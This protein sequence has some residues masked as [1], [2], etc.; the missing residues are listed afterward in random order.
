MSTRLIGKNFTPPDLRAKVTGAAKFAEDFRSEGMLHCRLLLSP[1]PNARVL[2]V[3]VSEALKVPGVVAVLTA[4]EVPKMPAPER[5][6]LT[7]TPRFLGDPILAIAA[8]TETAAADGLERIRLEL[9]ALPFVIDPV[10]SLLRHDLNARPEGNVAGRNLPLRTV[11]W[12]KNYLDAPLGEMPDDAVVESW[13]YGDLNAE[14]SKCGLVFEENFVTASFP[15]QSMEPRSAFAYW[16]RGKC[17]IHGSTQSQ[18]FIMPKLAKYVGIDIGNLVFVGEFCGGGFGSKDG[19]YPA[20]AIPA[21]MSKKTGRPVMM[22]ISRREEYFIGSARCGFQGRVKLGFSKDGKLLAV[23]MLVVQDNGANEGF[24]DFIAAGEAVSLVYRPI[25]M[26]Y[27]ALPVLTNTPWRGAQRGPGQNQVAVTLEPLIDKAA[28]QLGID[29]VAIRRINA[30]DGGARF[31]GKAKSVTSAHLREALEKAAARYGWNQKVRMER[32]ARPGKAIGIGVGQAY[33][34][35]GSRGFDGLVCIRPDGRLHIHTGVGNLGTYSYAATSRVAAEV[36]GYDWRRCVIERGDSRRHLPWNLGQFGSNTSFTMTRTNHVAAMDARR[37]I[38][39]IAALDLRGDADDLAIESERVFLRS[40]PS[41]GMSFSQVARRAIEL[42]G[43]YSGQVLPDDLNPMTKASAAALAGQGLIGVSKDNLESG[44]TVAAFAVGM[45]TVE[46]DLE[47]GH[48][49]ILDYVGV[50]DCGTVLHPQG[51]E[52]QISGGLAMGIGMACRERYVYDRVIGMPAN[53]SLYQCKP[54]TYL[55]LPRTMSWDAVE[56]PDPNN[57]VGSKGIGEPV[58][59]C[60]ASALVCAIS[61]ALDGHHFNRTPIS[62]DMIINAVR[63]QP[64]AHFPLQVHTV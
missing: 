32:T 45:M 13:S 39:A 33:H 55:E 59:G 56:I 35:A 48:V 21:H 14:F 30:P 22:R 24:D 51:L 57:P 38:L 3:D 25:A 46:L 52:Q 37:K 63:G 42:G 44:G 36:L 19:A 40:R 41:V 15:H 11:K 5:S 50:T 49:V 1:M 61:D 62:P 23:D 20:M 17:V 8:E 16:D 43:E 27:R 29:R 12:S 58:M 10:E 6:L 18:S 53:V 9:E 34:H 54:A 4:A 64:A 2:S 7:D 26:R 60:A 47:T 28:R 31:G